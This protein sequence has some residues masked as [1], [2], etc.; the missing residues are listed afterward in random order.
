MRT[1]NVSIAGDRE[2]VRKLRAL[3]LMHNVNI[4]TLVRRAIDEKYG[5]ELS[6]LDASLFAT[7]EPVSRS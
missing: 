4:S 2:F 7:S 3:A 1:T 5:K 6:R